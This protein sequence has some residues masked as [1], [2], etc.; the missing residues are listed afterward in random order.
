MTDQEDNINL[1]NIVCDDNNRGR[2]KN[3]GR[4]WDKLVLDHLL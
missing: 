4:V 2:E 1:G 3:R